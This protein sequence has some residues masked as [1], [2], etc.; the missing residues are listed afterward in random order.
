MNRRVGLNWI[1]PPFSVHAGEETETFEW[2]PIAGT[3]VCLEH[4]F[5]SG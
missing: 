3:F 2:E 4:A 5:V 1:T